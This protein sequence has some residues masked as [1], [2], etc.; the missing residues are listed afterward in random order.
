[1]VIDLTLYI[2]YGA[3]VGDFDDELTTQLLQAIADVSSVR[4]STSTYRQY[5]SLLRLR[6]LKISKVIDGVAR[7]KKCI[8]VLYGQYLQKVADGEGPRCIVSS[9]SADKL[10]LE[11]IHGTCTSLL[12]AAPNTIASGIYQCLAWLCVPENQP[13]QKEAVAAILAAYDGDRNKAWEMAFREEKVPLIVSLYKETLRFWAFSPY[14][15]R[16]L[17][18]TIDKLYGTTFPKGLEMMLNIQAVNH[19]ED[20]YGADAKKFVPG[21]FIDDPTPLPHL[22]YGTGGRICPAY[23]ISNR[24]IYAMLVR[25]LLAF[26]VKQADGPGMRLPSTDMIDFS[27][28][29]GLMAQPR[30]YDCVFVARD[31]DWLEKIQST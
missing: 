4:G 3:R 9:L 13:F 26:E 12:Q 19:D 5:V 16:R 24:I 1:M 6:P 23:Q 18:Q 29:Y 7:R 10:T 28:G 8:D 20:H 2:T 27:D 21:R 22:S 25:M 30:R 17:N 15:G 11:E 31:S 14:A